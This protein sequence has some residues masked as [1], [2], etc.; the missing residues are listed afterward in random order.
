MEKEKGRLDYF[1]IAK[2]ICFI[3]V[4]WGHF[5]STYGTIFC[6]TFNLPA[7]F[8][9]S[10]YFLNKKKSVGEYAAVKVQQLL[11]PYVYTGCV[12]IFLSFVLKMDVAEWIG[13]VI[14]GAGLKP[15]QPFMNVGFVGPIWFFLALYF[16]LIIARIGISSIWGSVVIVACVMVGYFS[17][18]LI[19]LPFGIQAGMVLSGYVYVGYLA[20]CLVKNLRPLISDE[21]IWQVTG[22]ITGV[23]VLIWFWYYSGEISCVLFCINEYPR[24]MV[25]Y[26][27]PFSA[28][29]SVILLCAFFIKYIPLISRG[30]KWIGQNTLTMLCIHSVDTMFFDWS[31]LPKIE[32]SI[33]WRTLVFMIICKFIVYIVLTVL[34]KKLKPMLSQ[35]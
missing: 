19:W 27:G 2:G 4:V 23:F 15:Q 14:Y 16:A 3:A 9:I 5:M 13:R 6:Y 30:L 35:R 24:G 31:F 26:F 18:Q 17:S 8:V 34:W 25:D 1:D 33:T 28:I 22:I 10:G 7:F 20:K 21:W 11:L 29:F 12:M 32:E